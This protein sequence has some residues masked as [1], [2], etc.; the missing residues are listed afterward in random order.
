VGQSV[1]LGCFAEFG[2][3]VIGIHVSAFTPAYVSRRLILPNALGALAVVYQFLACA[4]IVLDAGIGCG[5]DICRMWLHAGGTDAVWWTGFGYVTSK[6]AAWMWARLMASTWF[7]NGCRSGS[8]TSRP[9]T[10]LRLR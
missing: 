5:P 4:G 7:V 10:P 2:R 6:H 1:L 9:K 8:A 3:M